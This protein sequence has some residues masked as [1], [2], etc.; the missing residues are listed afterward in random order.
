VGELEILG[1]AHRLLAPAGARGVVVAVGPADARGPLPARIPVGHGDRLLVLDPEIAVGA[2]QEV[3]AAS[4]S[5][6][7][8]LS[9]RA[10]T[11]GRY[12]GRP[13]PDKPPFVTVGDDIAV[14]QTVCL[15]EVMKTFH[16]VTYG[17]DDLPSRARVTAIRPA[18]EDD[19]S[20]GDVILVLESI[21]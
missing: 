15:L 3:G 2:A 14:G 18:D 16:R 9:F 5:A 19:L 13:A 20:A 12:Y 11:S 7:D 1:V 4:A 6:A 10:P 17:G 21:R 8:G